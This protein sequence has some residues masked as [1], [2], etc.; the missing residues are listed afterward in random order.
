MTLNHDYFTNL[1]IPR[2]KWWEAILL[3]FRPVTMSAYY[4]DHVGV[5][6]YQYKKMFGRMYLTKVVWDPK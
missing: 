3:W 6:H 4:E 1:D 2:T 5:G